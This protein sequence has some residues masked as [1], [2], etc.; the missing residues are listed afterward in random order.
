MEVNICYSLVGMFV[1]KKIAEVLEISQGRRLRPRVVCE[2]N[3]I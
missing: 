1:W 3:Y 2:A